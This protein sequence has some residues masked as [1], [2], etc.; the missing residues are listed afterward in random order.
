LYSEISEPISGIILSSVTDSPEPCDTKS[1]V[2][3]EK[4]EVLAVDALAAKNIRDSLPTEWNGVYHQRIMTIGAIVD[5]LD[6]R[7]IL[8][9]LPH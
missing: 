5:K 1:Y 9:T 8:T 6:F 2:V 4:D 3:A 7:C